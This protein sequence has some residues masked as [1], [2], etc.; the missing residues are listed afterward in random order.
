[1][2]FAP[3]AKLIAEDGCG[4][5]I[6][7]SQIM[8]VRKVPMQ[9]MPRRSVTA[10]PV[11][12]SRLRDAGDIGHSFGFMARAAAMRPYRLLLPWSPRQISS[13]YK[14][15]HSSIF[16]TTNRWQNARRERMRLGLAR[17]TVW[18]LALWRAREC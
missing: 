11:L 8:R 12:M 16:A 9:Q 5:P 10:R 17:T 3:A 14:L 18:T 15:F 2:A 6:V 4:V 7:N 13:S 1:M